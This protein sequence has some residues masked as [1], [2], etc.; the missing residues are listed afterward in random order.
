VADDRSDGNLQRWVSLATTVIAPATVLGALLFYFGY[1]SSR[2]QFA[3]F[4]VDVD[5]IGL[6]TQDYVMRSP[7]PL[8]VPL[9][10]LTLL[11][12]GAMVL[13]ASIRQRIAATESGARGPVR[14]NAYLRVAH[15]LLLIG[16][17]LVIGGVV[18]LFA[19]ASLRDRAWY[20]LV[21]PLLLAGGATLVAYAA[22]LQHLLRPPTST[23]PEDPAIAAR[24]RADSSVHAL[25]RSA[26]VLLAVVIV[27]NVFWMTATVAQYS[28][29]GQAHALSKRLDTL[30]NVILDTRERL[31]LRDPGVEE[32]A[33]PVSPGQTFRYR[34]RHL[35]LLIQGHGLM[36]LVPDT[37]SASDSTLVVPLDESVRVQFQFENQTP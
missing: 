13:H 8:L 6:T 28:G 11:G 36:F 9:L 1:V 29:R 17:T 31:Y 2:A 18:L 24:A 33:L 12:V 22:R 25:R 10:V 35:R 21:T 27:A 23:D 37:W 15:R 19:Y 4:G 5:T 16:L 34:Y 32:T 20:G 30:P 3:Y 26:T 7:Q 14:L